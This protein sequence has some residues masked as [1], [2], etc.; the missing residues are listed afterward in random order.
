[1]AFWLAAAFWSLCP[2]LC[3]PRALRARSIAARVEKSL[4]PARYASVNGSMYS[5]HR[6]RQ[7]C[8]NVYSENAA[9]WAIRYAF[10]CRFFR[11]DLSTCP[12]RVGASAPHVHQSQQPRRQRDRE[13]GV[14]G[15]AK[16]DVKGAIP[17]VFPR[18]TEAL[19]GPQATVNQDGSNVS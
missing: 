6:V 12:L 18:Q 10:G 9:T 15:L 2:E 16:R 19:V 4:C 5:A 3:L 7:V 11:V 1:V 14:F 8:R 17:H 13:P